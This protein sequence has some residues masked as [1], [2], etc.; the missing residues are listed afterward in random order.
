MVQRYELFL[1]NPKT[2]R[3]Q[4]PLCYRRVAPY[5]KDGG[6]SRNRKIEADKALH[7]P[8]HLIIIYKA[9]GLAITAGPFNA[10]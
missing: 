6:N 4:E 5:R 1:K 7:P 10:F 2:Q 3:G 9:K 8:L